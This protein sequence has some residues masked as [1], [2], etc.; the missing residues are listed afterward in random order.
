VLTERGS[1]LSIGQRQ[2]LSLARVLAYDPAILVLDEATSS[3]DT[4]TEE[5]IQKALHEVMQNRTSLVVAHRLSTIR[6]CDRI[7]VLHKGVV[8]ESGTHRELLRQKGL[9]ARLYEL[10][11][12]EQAA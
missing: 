6:D 11:F 4:N 5:L 3:I 8:R 2:L 12:K 10:Q 1:T 7:L 9:Y